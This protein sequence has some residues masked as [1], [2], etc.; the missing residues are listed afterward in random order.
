MNIVKYLLRMNILLNICTKRY[1]DCSAHYLIIKN[2]WTL[3]KSI[4]KGLMQYKPSIK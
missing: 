2:N 4:Y 3:D 1:F